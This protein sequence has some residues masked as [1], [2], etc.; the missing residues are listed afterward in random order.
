MSAKCAKC[1]LADPV[2]GDTWCLG[3]AAWEAIERELTSKWA[4]PAG[5]RA[6]AENLVVGTAREIRA[7]RALGAGLGRAQGE[8]RAGAPGVSTASDPGAGAHR[9][10]QGLAPKSAPKPASSARRG[11]EEASGEYS[12][13]YTSDGE[14]EE[15]LAEKKRKPLERVRTEEEGKSRREPAELPPLKRTKEELRSTERQ[16]EEVE[17][18]KGALRETRRSRERESE[19]IREE[20]RREKKDKKKKKKRKNKKPKKRAG[21]RHKRVSRL[22]QDPY[23]QIHRG[24]STQFLD[25]RP[26]LSRGRDKAPR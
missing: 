1:K 26:S 14:E 6:I 15:D 22:A 7:L 4:G 11:G 5:L 17:E 9:A 8:L 13:T 19:R 12:Y 20:E 21:R 25:S 23:K 3:C 10:P 24:L 2:S 16:R 18:P